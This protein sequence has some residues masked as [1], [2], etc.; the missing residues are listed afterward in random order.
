[1]LGVSAWHMYR[2]NEHTEFFRKT[3][4]MTAVFTLVMSLLV[5]LSG[6]IQGRNVANYQPS[7]LAAM[8]GHWETGTNV[9]F[10]LFAVPNEANE[11]A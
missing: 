2:K 6:D 8:E 3:F 9:P 5:A 4:R 10:Y 11:V 7:K 1:M